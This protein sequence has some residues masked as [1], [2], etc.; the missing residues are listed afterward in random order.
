[1]HLLNQ[2][3]L[4]CEISKTHSD[5]IFYPD[6]AA[7]F[8]KYRLEGIPAR[9]LMSTRKIRQTLTYLL[10]IGIGGLAS[11]NL[12]FFR[13]FSVAYPPGVTYRMITSESS[14][15]DSV[16]AAV[17]PQYEVSAFGEFWLGKHYRFLWTTP[18]KAPVLNLK[19]EGLRLT[20]R[21][22]G[23]QTTSFTL[24][25]E[26]GNSYSLRSV[27]KDPI[28]VI[29]VFL[30]RTVLGDFI[31]DQVSAT[32]PFALPAVLALTKAAGISSGK[33]RLVFV[34]KQ[35]PAFK[36]YHLPGNGFYYLTPK[37]SQPETRHLTPEERPRIY[38]TETMLASLKRNKGNRIDTALYLRCRLFDLFISDWDRHAGQWDWAGFSAG[39][40][41]VFYPLPKDRDQAFGFY[42][43]G[44]FPYL[45]TRNFAARKISS[46]TPYYEDIEGFA[47]NG[48][49]LDTIF[50]KTLSFSA[51]KLQVQELQTRLN[52][53][54]LQKAL[55]KY[56]EPVLAKA[57]GNLF[58]T[59][60]ARRN[61]LLPA[62]KTFSEIINRSHA[63]N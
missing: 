14:L 33:A 1:M 54:V 28:S 18:V 38:A 13:P 2:G 17:G 42:N 50:L 44:V 47:Q 21:G 19:K 57:S 4:G 55:Q 52:D 56:P 34:R 43:D 24:K 58:K 3:R 25:D 51:Y 10:V 60:Q 40:D 35:D 8:Q 29:P 48:H 59:L 9:N 37:I 30:W 5:R 36:A 61:K 6:L 27:D 49:D 15:T 63:N 16:E 11:W 46:L 45:L 32:D 26:A 39:N 62:A 7:F 12:S 20:K 41:T 53:Q 23:M 22:G 31:R